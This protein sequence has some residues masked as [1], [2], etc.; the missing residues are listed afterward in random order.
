MQGLKTTGI[1]EVLLSHDQTTVRV[2]LIQNGQEFYIEIPTGNLSA[3]MPSLMKAIT[4]AES[5]G[6]VTTIV[7]ERVT[8]D[9]D[10]AL[11]VLLTLTNT[12]GANATFELS[13]RQA[14]ELSALLDEAHQIQSG[15]TRKH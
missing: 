13:Q 8:V 7:A 3:A 15:S 12:A 14:V 4:T 6:K 9:L 5:S 1:K 2:V 11:R 10:E